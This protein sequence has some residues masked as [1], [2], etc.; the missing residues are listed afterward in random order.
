M[1]RI[2]AVVVIV[3][4]IGGNER[5]RWLFYSLVLLELNEGFDE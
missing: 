2:G 1:R 3:V 4:V 5:R